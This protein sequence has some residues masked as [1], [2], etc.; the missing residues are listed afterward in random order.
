MPA[1]TQR[2]RRVR[3]R[4]PRGGFRGTRAHVRV[5]DVAEGSRTAVLAALAGNG[6]LALSKGVAAAMT[7]STAMIAETLHSIADTGNQLLLLVGM[8]LA[9]RPPDD[10]HPFGYGSNVYFW[11]F[12]VAGLIFTIGGSA[13]ILEGIETLRHPSP[14]ESFFWAYA[15]LGASVVFE[16]FGFVAGMRGVNRDRGRTP[17]H[18]YLHESRDPTLLVV[19]CEDGAALVSIGIA[20]AGLGLTQATGNRM[21]DGAASCLIGLLLVGVAAFLAYETY[22]LLIGEPATQPLRTQIRRVV[23]GDGDVDRLVALHT[24]HLGP[25]TVLVALGV[26]FRPDLSAADVEHGVQR[27]QTAIE[28]ELD[29]LTN[30]RLILIEPTSWQQ[31]DRPAATAP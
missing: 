25:E 8:R 15:V 1:V 9:R 5:R 19:V 17:L 22:S 28:R 2:V 6:A 12:V 4:R 23:E 7:G 29:G 11:S 18:Q 21:W 20:L 31:R 24:L 30:P 26:H 13:A 27:L 14:P 16:S 3:R 10:S